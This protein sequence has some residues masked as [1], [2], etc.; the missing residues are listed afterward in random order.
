MFGAGTVL[1][2]NGEGIYV[3]SLDVTSGALELFSV[4]EWISRQLQRT[5]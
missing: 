4:A 1:N 2:G 3:Y 5:W